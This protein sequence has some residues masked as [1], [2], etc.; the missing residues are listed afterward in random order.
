MIS[1]YGFR[2]LASLA[3]DKGEH[4]F[5]MGK[6]SYEWGWGCFH[7]GRMGKDKVSHFPIPIHLPEEELVDWIEEQ[8]KLARIIR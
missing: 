1:R 6:F 3:K 5:L 4:Q 2:C 8:F 7:V